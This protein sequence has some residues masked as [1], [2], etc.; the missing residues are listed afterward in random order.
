MALLATLYDWL[1]VVHVL[2]AMVWVG[3]LATAAAFGISAA[4]AHDPAALGAIVASLRRISPLLF[5]L[6][7]GLLVVFGVLMVLDSPAWDFGQRWIQIAFVLLVAAAAV[8]AGLARRAMEAAGRALEGG[9]AAAASRHVAEWG[10]VIGL[11]L[12]LLVL[13]TCDMILK[14]G[15]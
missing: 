6:P 2:A 8:G 15:L 1:M 10:R 11:I 13:A 9:D 12:V 4:R 14:P 5:G 7:A 3:G